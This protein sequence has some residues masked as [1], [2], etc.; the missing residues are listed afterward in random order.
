MTPEETIDGKQ[1]VCDPKN[2]TILFV[3]K[4]VIEPHLG[5]LSFFKVV[6]GEIKAGSDLINNKT[7]AMERLNQL[8]IMDGKNRNPVEKLVAGD[9]GATLKLKNTHTN[10]TLHEKGIDVAVKPIVFPDPKI[11]VAIVAKNKNDDEKLSEALKEI[12][13]E[14]P[15]VLIEYSR[16]LKQI[17]L[18]GQGELH[19]HVLPYS[20]RW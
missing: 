1:I 8:F 2:T 15:T 12:H 13:E 9:I 3:F 6:S 5:K 17:L 19:L 7:G 14:D 10:N 11:R 18:S 20:S 4:T 16:E